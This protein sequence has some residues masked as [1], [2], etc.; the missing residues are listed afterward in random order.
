MSK[1]ETTI[2]FFTKNI[3]KSNILQFL[4]QYLWRVNRIELIITEETDTQLTYRTLSTTNMVVMYL[5]L[6]TFDS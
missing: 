6:R 1:I 3:Y 5:Q 4:L 2:F